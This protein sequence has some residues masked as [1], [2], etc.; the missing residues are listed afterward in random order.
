MYDNFKRAPRQKRLRRDFAKH[1]M[2]T[3]KIEYFETKNGDINR[4]A[5]VIY[6][7]ALL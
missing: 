4:Q 5:S 1:V 3:L 7:G 6:R 2:W